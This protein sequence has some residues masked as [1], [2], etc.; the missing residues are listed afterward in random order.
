VLATS[1]SLLG[2]TGCGGDEDRVALAITGTRWVDDARL[3]LTTE[4]AE[5][6][7]RAWVTS[8]GAEPPEVT[9]WGSPKVGT[10]EAVAEIR[11][12]PGITKIVDGATSQVVDLPPRPE[13]S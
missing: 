6:E 10:C 5:L 3:E 8:R 12:V 13:P 4:C 1:A 11:L 9:V 2:A 7:G